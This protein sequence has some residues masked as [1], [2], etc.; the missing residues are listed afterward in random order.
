MRR[1]LLSLLGASLY[2]GLTLA[3][4][5]SAPAQSV[6]VPAGFTPPQV[7]KNTN[8]LRNIDITRPYT[9]EIIAVIVE[10]ISDKPQSEYYV[11][12]DAALA[13]DV[14][15]VEAR[16][17]KGPGGEFVVA[18]VD[19]AGDSDTKYYQITFTQPLGLGEQLTLQLA[20]GHLNV[21]TPVPAAVGQVDKQFLRWTGTQYFASAYVT[22][23]QKTKLKLPTSEAPDYTKLEPKSDGTS[24]P[25]KAGPTVTYGPYESVSPA[26][27]GGKEVA[28][29][30]EHTAPVVKMYSLSRSIEV[31][32]WGGNLAFEEQYHMTNAGAALKSQFSRVAWAA[33]NYYN[34]P[35][36]AIKALTFNLGPGASDPYYTDE[37]GN[38]STSRFRSGAREAHLE[39]KPRFPLFGGWNA[40]FV[41]G[42][43]HAL[44]DFLRVRP[45]GEEFV[46]RVPL[47]EGPKEP[48]FYDAV[49]VTVILP[50]GA[51]DVRYESPVPVVAEKRYLHHT[52]MDTLGRTALRLEL[53]KVADEHHR[54]ELVVAYHLPRWAFLRKPFVMFS[55]AMTMFT[56]SWVVSKVNLKI[57]R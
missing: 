35:T 17:K 26:Q 16:D 39:I 13:E 22:E 19:A 7:F 4:T 46:L 57:G 8:L 28:V 9:R 21:M 5:S 30:F 34:P 38:I 37:V 15:Y 52:F 24:D 20:I 49:D 12:F 53:R 29:R 31:S 47:L 41:I 51:T 10:N 2:A 44:S 48:V 11:P 1:S 25:T 36:H 43:N 33:T 23:K 42:W 32:H 18:K 55:A 54:K 3:L 6:S 40:S 56:F 50:E 27:R 14:S 45:G